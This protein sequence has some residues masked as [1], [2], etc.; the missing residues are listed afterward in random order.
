MYFK[1]GKTRR[2]RKKAPNFIILYNQSI[3]GEQTLSVACCHWGLWISNKKSMGEFDA[4]S[5]V[6]WLIY[7]DA[8]GAR[9]CAPN[10]STSPTA[11]NLGA[12]CKSLQKLGLQWKKR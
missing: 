11:K 12:I 3:I 6:Q 4:V 2:Q 5:V 8:P 1:D 7:G 10:R 9:I